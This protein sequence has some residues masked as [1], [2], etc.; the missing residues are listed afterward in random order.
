MKWVKDLQIGLEVFGWQ[1]L[2]IQTLSGLLLKE[3]STY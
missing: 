1:G 2:D 3:G